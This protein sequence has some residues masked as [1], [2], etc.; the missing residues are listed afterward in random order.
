MGFYVLGWNIFVFLP[1]NVWHGH[2]MIYGFAMAVVAGF[3]LTA[4]MNWTGQVTARGTPL[5]ILFL[6]WAA[7]RVLAFVPGAGALKAMA[8]ADML[9]LGGLIAVVRGSLQDASVS[10]CSGAVFCRRLA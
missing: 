5:A 7:G 6:F 2:E 3:L 8:L 1:V 10:Y 4:V 9:F